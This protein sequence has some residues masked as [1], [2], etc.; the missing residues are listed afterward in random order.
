[1]T[2]HNGLVLVAFDCKGQNF[3]LLF[4]HLGCSRVDKRTL[5]LTID[6][7]ILAQGT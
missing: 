6:L 5:G 3:F 2:F 7:G 1:V 4:R